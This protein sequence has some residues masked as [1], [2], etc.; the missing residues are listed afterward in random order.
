MRVF[1]KKDGKG[2]GNLNHTQRVQS[3]IPSTMKM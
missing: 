1:G 2:S 3:P